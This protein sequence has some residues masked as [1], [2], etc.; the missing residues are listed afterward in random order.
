MTSVLSKAERLLLEKQKPNSS[1]F[2]WSGFWSRSHLHRA[3]VMPRH[4]LI[5]LLQPD[6]CSTKIPFLR[7]IFAELKK[8]KLFFPL[9]YVFFFFFYPTFIPSCHHFILN[10]TCCLQQSCLWP[11]G[12]LNQRFFPQKHAPLLTAQITEQQV[13]P[14]RFEKIRGHRN[15]RKKTFFRH[16]I[17]CPNCQHYARRQHCKIVFLTAAIQNNE[18]TVS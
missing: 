3:K 11:P 7:Q 9:K 1:Y 13:L 5:L 8:L 14:Q 12:C 18:M 2:L 6:I 16:Q 17:F 4:F 15:T 10:S